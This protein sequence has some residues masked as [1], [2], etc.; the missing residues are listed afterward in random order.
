MNLAIS[1]QQIIRSTSFLVL[2]QGFRGRRI[3]WRYFRLDQIQDGGSP[4][5]LENLN[6]DIS[7]TNRRIHFMFGSRVGFLG[8]ADRM[9]LFPFL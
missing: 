4:A 1:L 3:D 8:L 6:G 5:I 2:G 9:A 7:T